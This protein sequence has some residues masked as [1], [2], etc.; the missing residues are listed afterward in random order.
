MKRKLKFYLKSIIHLIREKFGLYDIQISQGKILNML[1]NYNSKYSCLHDF[2]FKV[3]S[4]RGEDGIIQFLINNVA[5]PETSKVFVE[6]GVETY[7]ESN[8][9][10]LLINNNWSGLVI[11]GDKDNTNFIKRDSIFYNYNLKVET[12][13]ITKSNINQIL[14]KNNLTGEV[15]ILSID[16][17]GNDYWI[18]ESISSID[19]IIVIIEYNSLFGNIRAITTPYDDNFQRTKYHYSNLLFGS[20]LKA[21]CMLAE[22]KKYSLVGT[23]STGTNAFFI[24]NDKIGALKIFDHT[25]GYTK[26]QF[27]EARDKNGKILGTMNWED[28]ENLIRGKIVFDVENSK[29]IQF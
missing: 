19:P 13:F 29:A 17:D 24:R 9:R 16:I 2:E 15:G 18:W 4:Q 1:N 28:K 11:D 5:I 6:F 20:S 27:T 25:N 3:F 8:T 23:N 12:A 14:K 21:L 22:R 26:A 10:F 7:I